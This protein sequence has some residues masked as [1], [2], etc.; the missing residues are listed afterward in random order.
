M[1]NVTLK[2]GEIRQYEAGHN[3]FGC[4]QSPW[5]RALQGCLCM[6]NQR[7]AMRFAH[8]VAGWL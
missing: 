7:G 5:I 8:R 2:G 4:C 1:I 6:Q 3:G